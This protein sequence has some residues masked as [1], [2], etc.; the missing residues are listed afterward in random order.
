MFC[1]NLNYSSIFLCCHQG[2]YGTEA[3]VILHN[4]HILQRFCIISMISFGNLVIQRS[5]QY[6]WIMLH[7]TICIQTNP[8]CT[9]KC[10]YEL[11]EASSIMAELC[12]LLTSWHRRVFRHPRFRKFLKLSKDIVK[13]TDFEWSVITNLLFNVHEERLKR[14][15]GQFKL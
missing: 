7:H 9:Y 13:K 2:F 14:K 5:L 6:I 8:N 10:C 3:G 12:V 4:S 11:H 15:Q 1:L